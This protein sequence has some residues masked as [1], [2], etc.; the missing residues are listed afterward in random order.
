LEDSLYRERILKLETAISH[1]NKPLASSGQFYSTVGIIQ[2]SKL[3]NVYP[4][5]LPNQQNMLRYQ[6][7]S[8]LKMTCQTILHLS[9]AN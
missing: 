9:P 3:Q 6:T 8:V 7:Y 2:C 5:L 1:T 4:L